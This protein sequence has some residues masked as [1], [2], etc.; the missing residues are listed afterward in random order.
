MCIN[1][2]TYD[3]P[4][5]LTCTAELLHGWR[6]VGFHLCDK[7]GA[8]FGWKTCPKVVSSFL[9]QQTSPKRYYGSDK[10][11]HQ[12]QQQQQPQQQQQQQ[13]QQQHHHHHHH[14]QQQ[15]DTTHNK[16]QPSKISRLCI[17][18]FGTV[19][20]TLG[21]KNRIPSFPPVALRISARTS[22]AALQSSSC[23]LLPCP[24]PHYHCNLP[25]RFSSCIHGT[26]NKLA[27]SIFF[28]RIRES[29]WI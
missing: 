19:S 10:T 8:C 12:Q 16:H 2:C 29:H 20:P 4:M 5:I 22:K 15:Q 9:Q 26:G 13:Q 14:H 28:W 17:Q 11:T 24:T 27:S 3:R 25:H 23:L 1:L 6:L 7:W 21:P 18:L